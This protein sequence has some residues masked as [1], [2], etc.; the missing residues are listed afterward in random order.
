[1]VTIPFTN[2]ASFCELRLGTFWGNRVANE[3]K[4]ASCESFVHATVY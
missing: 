2:V 1:M 3:R 4:T